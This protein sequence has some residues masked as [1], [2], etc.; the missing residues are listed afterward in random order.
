MAKKHSASKDVT[1]ATVKLLLLVAML[2]IVA[3]VY[4]FPDLPSTLREW[5]VLIFIGGPLY[6]VAEA[7]LDKIFR[8]VLSKETGEKI[9]KK[10]FSVLRLLI[11]L[12]IMGTFIGVWIFISSY[13]GWT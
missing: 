5:I 10:P 1:S 11:L 4:T 3:L 7:F 6:L 13:F 8:R 9:S 12:L 2:L